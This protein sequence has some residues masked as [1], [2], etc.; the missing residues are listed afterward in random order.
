M[1]IKTIL[2]DAHR[3]EAADKKAELSQF[4]THA[5]EHY[6]VSRTLRGRLCSRINPITLVVKHEWWPD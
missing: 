1:D 4:A 2:F 6:V 3:A 5:T